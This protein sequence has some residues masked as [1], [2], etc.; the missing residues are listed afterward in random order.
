MSENSFTR[1]LGTIRCYKPHS[2]DPIG[3][4]DRGCGA[5][6]TYEL[7]LQNP[8]SVNSHHFGVRRVVP[9]GVSWEPV[10]PFVL[11]PVSAT[12]V[13]APPVARA[14]VWVLDPARIPLRRSRPGVRRQR[15][16]RKYHGQHQ[17]LYP[18]HPIL[19]LYPPT[20]M[21]EGAPTPREIGSSVNLHLRVIR[22]W[23]RR[24]LVKVQH[25]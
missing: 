24:N 5:Q 14:R 2:P 17:E 13:L 8:L 1:T 11:A 10:P 9:V 7:P 12:A 19:L 23:R 20:R 15:S 22:I 25:G 18:T 21:I 4:V 3:F 16:R 6:L